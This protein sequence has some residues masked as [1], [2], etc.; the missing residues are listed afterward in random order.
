GDPGLHGVVGQSADRVAV[1]GVHFVD[2]E[3]SG[4]AGRLS[5]AVATHHRD[6]GVLFGGGGRIVHP[7]GAGGLTGG[8]GGPVA[9]DPGVRAGVDPDHGGV[10][11]PVRGAF[12]VG[13]TGVT[14]LTGSWGS[15]WGL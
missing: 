8:V 7:V 15:T 1:D 2:A 5:A 11:D 14:V 6:R 3:R 10:V 12:A 4:R 13:V 9:P